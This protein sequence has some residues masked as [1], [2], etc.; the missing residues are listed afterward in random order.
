MKSMSNNDIDFKRELILE[1][2]CLLDR[3]PLEFSLLVFREVKHCAK[4]IGVEYLNLR[5]F[6]EY[7]YSAD[8]R[9]IEI[10]LHSVN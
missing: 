2:S 10:A 3:C 1:T 6:F 8:F 4:L 7:H 5:K 9:S